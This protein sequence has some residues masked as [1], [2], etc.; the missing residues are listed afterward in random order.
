MREEVFLLKNHCLSVLE[1]F[2]PDKLIAYLEQAY[3][4]LGNDGL[5]QRFQMLV[6]PDSIEWQYETDTQSWGRQCCFDIFKTCQ[7]PIL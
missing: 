4:G 5:L 3:S 6:Y 7:K 2:K 1:A